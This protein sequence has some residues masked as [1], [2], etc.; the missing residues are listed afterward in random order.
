MTPC[1]AGTLYRHGPSGMMNEVSLASRALPPKGRH[2][3]TMTDDA[4]YMHRAIELAQQGRGWTSPNPLAGAVIVQGD[5]IVGEG[6]HPQV[7]QSH[8]E[9]FAL[10]AA[11]EAARGGTLFLSLEPCQ[12]AGRVSPCVDRILQA[13]ITRVVV[14]CE[15]A[16]PLSAGRGIKALQE[17]GLEVTVGIERDRARQLNEIFFKYITTKRPFVALRSAMSLDGKI[18]TTLGESQYIGGAEAEEHLQQLRASYDA[19]LI[20]VTTVLQDNPE[21]VCTVPRARNPLRIVID[22]LARTPTNCKLLSKAGT[23]LLRPNTVIVVT[24]QAPEERIRALQSV[25]A[26]ILVAPHIGHAMEAHVDLSKLMQIL[27]RR[28][29]TSVL[30]EGGGNLNAAALQ[31]SIVD[32]IYCTIAPLIIGGQSAL[33]PVEGLGAT[34]VEEA[35]RLYGMKCRSLGDDVLIEAYLHET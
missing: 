35:V 10:D 1:G 8:A 7:G 32:K 26:E 33:T 3:S 17:A 12:Y 29:I 4:T 9:I 14:G 15:D 27:G 5:Q 11:G 34:F 6:F 16:N 31:A 19:V 21:V 20:G 13:G 28:E 22:S 25:G 24:R 30:I 18:A 2:S 23:G